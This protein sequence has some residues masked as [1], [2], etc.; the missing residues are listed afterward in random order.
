LPAAV[1]RG[2]EARRVALASGGAAAVP[3]SSVKDTSFTWDTNEVPDGVY[4]VKVVASDKPSNPAGAL[5]DQAISQPFLV[6]NVPPTL[7]LGAVTVGSDKTVTVRGVAQTKI[8]FVKAVQGRADGGD[9]VAALADDGLFDSTLEP[10]TLT[11]GPLTPGAHAVE[12]QAVDQA[13][14]PAT[15]KVNVTVP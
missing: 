3:A 12:V 15:A 4:Q 2:L 7:T 8:A 6:A 10:F 5:T 14:N 11:L 9:S 1:R 13:G